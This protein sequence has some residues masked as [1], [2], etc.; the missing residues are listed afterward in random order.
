MKKFLIYSLGVVI[1]YLIVNLLFNGQQIIFPIFMISSFVFSFFISKKEMIYSFSFLTMIWFIHFF[2]E[3]SILSNIIIYFIFTPLT[4]FLGFY[5]K[6]KH[7]L[8]KGTYITI[9]ILIGVYG[10]SNFWFFVTNFDAHQAN[11]SPIMVFSSSDNK[12]VRLDTIKN[13]VIVL[14]Y[15]TTSCGVCFQKFPKYE[16]LYFKYKE[17]PNVLIYAVNI[18]ERRDTVGYAKKK[19][20][21]YKYQ[22]PVLYSDSDTI[23]KILGF[24]KFPHLVIL[25][26]KK[27]RYNGYPVLDKNY[28][29]HSL[30]EEIEILLNE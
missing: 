3:A 29:V 4:F 21:K 6:K 27:V 19:I 2:R 11:D 5:L 28:L 20:E 14:D 8:L 25:K 23:P 1:F 10:F 26:N 18:P 7:Y 30:E 17:N 15:W 16:E 13:K 12:Q 22:F 9:L 24:N